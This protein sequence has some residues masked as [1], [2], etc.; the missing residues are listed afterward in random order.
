[1]S[2]TNPQRSAYPVHGRYV[3]DGLI[4]TLARQGGGMVTHRDM[5]REIVCAPDTLRNVINRLLDKGILERTGFG[6][7]VLTE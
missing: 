4:V 6:V 1:M 3:V 2:K 7:Y 5:R